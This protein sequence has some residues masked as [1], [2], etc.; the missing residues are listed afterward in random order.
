MTIN[1]LTIYEKKTESCALAVP[2]ENRQLENWLAKEP[3]EKSE[4]KDQRQ[5]VKFVCLNMK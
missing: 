1:F 3:H 4:E 5:K 2:T